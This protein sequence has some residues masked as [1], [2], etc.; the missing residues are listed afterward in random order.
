ML[1]T[2][3]YQKVA[4]FFQCYVGNYS[5]GVEAVVES[6][7]WPTQ[8]SHPVLL[9]FLLVSI[10]CKVVLIV[11]LS[12]ALLTFIHAKAISIVCS[13]RSSLLTFILTYAILI[14]CLLRSS[15]A[16]IHGEIVDCLIYQL[17]DWHLCTIS[18]FSSQC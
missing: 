8:C 1:M 13:L 16:S 17:N 9:R 11:V 6:R 15:L 10:Y 7:K 3:I 5:R 2:S 18:W 14:V 4:C 12:R